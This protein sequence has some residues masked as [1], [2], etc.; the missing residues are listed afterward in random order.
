MPLL[1]SLLTFKASGEAVR[2]GLRFS[3]AAWWF[4]PIM[5]RINL[6]HHGNPGKGGI[7]ETQA[8]TWSNEVM[9]NG[10]LFSCIVA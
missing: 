4:L 7:V 6:S 3:K 5:T 10:V 2:L 9:N 8:K 1:S